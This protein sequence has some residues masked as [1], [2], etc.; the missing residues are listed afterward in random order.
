MWRLCGAERRSISAA[1]YKAMRVYPDRSGG[2]SYPSKGFF[3][4]L[5][6]KLEHAIS[7]KMGVEAAPLGSQ[8]G[9]L[10]SQMAKRTGLLRGTLI[11]VGNIDAHVAVPACTVTQPGKL[12]MIIGNLDLSLAP[13]GKS[14][15][16]R[17]HLWGGPRR[18]RSRPLG[19]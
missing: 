6:P 12:V 18:D 10:G 7:E 14:T 9:R 1:G 8:A 16:R 19:I 5:H 4:A 11:A 15:Q 17:R 2:W 13:C 3:R